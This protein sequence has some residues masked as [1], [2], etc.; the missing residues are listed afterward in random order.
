MAPGLGAAIDRD[1]ARPPSHHDGAVT[2]SSLQVKTCT[3][4]NRCQQ[5][6]K[7]GFIVA[8]QQENFQKFGI[9]GS[10]VADMIKHVI[11]C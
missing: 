2:I 6:R 9:D 10:K 5:G 1:P 11:M 8:M 3:R 4:M 7:L